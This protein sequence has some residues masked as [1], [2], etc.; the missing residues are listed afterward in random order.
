MSLPNKIDEIFIYTAIHAGV[1]K[2][3]LEQGICP[4]EHD[5]IC[6][7][8]IDCSFRGLRSS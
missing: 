7:S 6:F 4:V 5:E 1:T 3:L 2:F 8:G